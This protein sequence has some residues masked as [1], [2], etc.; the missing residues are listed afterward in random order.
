MDLS[1]LYYKGYAFGA[2]KDNADIAFA[3]WKIKSELCVGQKF[4]FSNIQ[5][6]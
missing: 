1:R 4:E 6:E 2:L 3:E 5:Y